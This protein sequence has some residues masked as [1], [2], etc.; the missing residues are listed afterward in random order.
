[1]F[2]FFVFNLSHN[3]YLAVVWVVLAYYN[4]KGKWLWLIKAQTWKGKDILGIDSGEAGVVSLTPWQLW[5]RSSS[6]PT[7]VSVSPFR[8]DPFLYS[9]LTI[10]ISSL[11]KFASVDDAMAILVALRS[12]EIEVIGL[13]TIYGNVYTTLATRNAL[14]LVKKKRKNKL[15]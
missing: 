9:S 12:P 4:W 3:W 7:L 11:I 15:N 13:T 2:L 10:I 8:L 14:H 1:M 6:T 5:R